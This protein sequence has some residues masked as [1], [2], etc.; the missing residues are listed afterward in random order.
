MVI[1]PFVAVWSWIW[2]VWTVILPFVAACSGIWCV[3][4]HF[5][6]RGGLELDLVRV[7]G[8]F[9]IHSNASSP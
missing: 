7:D 6:F 9:T 8:H 4:G 3:D 5:T 2:C 1:L